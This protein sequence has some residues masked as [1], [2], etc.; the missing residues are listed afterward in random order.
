MDADTTTKKDQLMTELSTAAE[1]EIYNG[2]I[3]NV[4]PTAI[5]DRSVARNIALINEDRGDTDPFYVMNL[6]TV[7]DRFELWRRTLPRVQPYYAVKCNGNAVLLRVLADLGVGFDCA[8][9][10]EIDLILD[11]GLATPERIIY[12]NPCKTRNFVKH[13]YAR[14]VDMMT[15]DNEEELIKVK[16][17]HPQARYWIHRSPFNTALPKE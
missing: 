15:F 12:A 3:L 16:E 13:A 17:S 6:G 9:K 2:V 8:S 11:N 10:R 4:L 14:G 5:D 1:T 7:I